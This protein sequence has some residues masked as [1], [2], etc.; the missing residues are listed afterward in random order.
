MPRHVIA[1][2]ERVLPQKSLVSDSKR[3]KTTIFLNGPLDL[4]ELAGIVV[5]NLALP[6]CYYWSVEE[7][8]EWVSKNINPS[9]KEAFIQNFINGRKLITVNASS[10]PKMNIHDFEEITKITEKIRSLFNMDKENYFRSIALPPEDPMVMYLQYRSKSG[11]SYDEMTRVDF[12]RKMGILSPE[13][14][15]LCHWYSILGTKVS[16]PKNLAN[17]GGIIRNKEKLCVQN[18]KY[19]SINLHSK[20]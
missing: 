8:G 7:V 16:Y 1:F 17:S 19:K 11:K 13:K 12:F 4:V 6:E 14:P 15:V 18:D 3:F 5:N 2:S 9:Y 10:L 20:G